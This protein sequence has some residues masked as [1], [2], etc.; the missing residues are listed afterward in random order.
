MKFR[1]PSSCCGVYLCLGNSDEQS[2]YEQIQK[3]KSMVVN[4]LQ[5][6]SHINYNH[7]SNIKCVGFKSIYYAINLNTVLSFMVFS[8]FDYL[9]QSMY[10]FFESMKLFFSLKKKLIKKLIQQ[11]SHIY[12]TYFMI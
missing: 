8:N 11:I 5:N 9:F 3:I 4:I 1:F 2:K 7:N 6:W 10:C 12:L